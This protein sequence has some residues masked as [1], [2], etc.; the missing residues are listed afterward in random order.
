MK[1]K[2][3]DKSKKLKKSRIK[4]SRS[5]SILPKTKKELTYDEKEF[6]TQNW[7]PVENVEYGMIKL[8]AAYGGGYIKIVEVESSNFILYPPEEK[9][10]V[11]EDMMEWLRI[12]PVSLQFKMI[13]QKTDV[14]DL[15]DSVMERTKNET[16]KKVIERRN[17]Y[18]KKIKECSKT[19]GLTKRFF[20]IF[21]YEGDDTGYST[22]IEEIQ[23]TMYNT[24]AYIRYFFGR[25]GNTLIEHE[26]DN[27]FLVKLL[28]KMFNPRT[29]ATEDFWRRYSR[30]TSDYKLYRDSV[31]LPELELENIPLT[32]YISPKGI[33]TEYKDCICYDGMFETHIYI[34]NDGYK[35]IVPAGWMRVLTEFGE[36]VDVNVYAVK[37]NTERSLEQVKRTIR[38]RASEVDENSYKEDEQETI[39]SQKSN[40]KYIKEMMSNN[41]EDLYDVMMM[42]SIR[43]KNYAKCMKRKKHIENVL[44]SKDLRLG[45]CYQHEEEAFRMSLPLLL[46]NSEIFSKGKRN[47]L[48]SSLAASYF[49][50][51]LDVYDP[52][53]FFLGVNA[54]DSSLVVTDIFNNRKFSNSNMSIY[55]TSGMGK[56]YLLQQLSYA[57]RES[58]V[59]VLLILP[60]KGFEYYRATMEIGGTFVTLAPGANTCINVMA[61]RPQGELDKQL[62][63]DDSYE[64][65]SLLSKKIHQIT[66][67]ISLLMP[68]DEITDVEE[69]ELNVV[70]SKIYND[71]GITQNNDSIWLDKKN[72]IIRPMPIIGD[73]YDACLTNEILNER[74][75]TILRPFVEGICSNMNAQTNVDLDNKY[76]AFDISGAGK[77][78]MAAFM[79]IAVDCAY[80]IVKRDRTERCALE[81]D[82][83]WRMMTNTYCAEFIMEIY[84][85]IRGYGGSAVS[86]TQD[87]GDY[88]SFEGGEYGKRIIKLSAIKFLLGAEKT[89]LDDLS[90]HIDLT[91]DEMKQLL[92]YG[93]GQA[94]MVT[95]LEKI[96]LYI[97]GTQEETAIFTTDAN[98]IRASIEREKKKGKEATKE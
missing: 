74:I 54:N 37:K 31:S 50:F 61:I 33:S 1:N 9:D 75:S 21:K 14:N 45:D 2:E 26:D 69:T 34:R 60:D 63:L 98:E 73:L 64:I 58:G 82:E 95:N 49:M 93:R 16:N 70:L 56:T 38:H 57:L 22:N 88:F 17:H 4:Q 40:A 94:L 23:E 29:C 13:T 89:D 42:I 18:I 87:I 25:M 80:D 97:K 71:F 24:E 43:D 32:D 85:I 6:F 68:K 35:E 83:V 62:V 8:K 55:G 15:I 79:F 44:K 67:F 10:S 78:Y 65:E 72:K 81:M 92:K 3:K 36:N 46:I 47:F 28:Y 76:I 51:A 20:I 86:A 90:A 53:G 91:R 52:N 59:T 7:N 11:I 66:T 39:L 27:V 30:V 77:K 12:A 41:G 19:E 48:T 84:K 96:P 5:Q